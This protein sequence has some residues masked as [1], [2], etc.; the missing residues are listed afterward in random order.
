MLVPEFL[1]I[2]ILGN[3]LLR[4]IAAVVVLLLV[5]FTLIFVRSL[6]VRYLRAIAITTETDLDDL[7][8]E[9]ISR[10]WKMN[11]LAIAIFA[12]SLS[13][14]VSQKVEFLMASLASVAL[15]LQLG[16]WGNGIVA[17]LVTR[18]RKK[19]DKEEKISLAAYS[20]ISW[21]SR[22]VLWS[23]VALLALNNL[24]IEVTALVA[25]L[26]ISGI[27][28]ALAVQNILGDLFASLSIVLD[29]PFEVGD[30][31]IVEDLMGVVQH[32]GIK[33]TRVMS[34]S[35]EQIVFS[36]TDLLSSRIRNYRRMKERRVL[37]GFGVTY[38]TTSEQ[39][40]AIPGII[41]EIV[42][43]LEM[44]RFDR[45]HFKSFG[46]SSLDFEVVYFVQDREYALFMDIQQE[47]NLEIMKRFEKAGIEFAYPTQTLFIE[48]E[49]V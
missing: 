34:I 17:Y 20:A 23:F 39:V 4:W 47:I 45:A 30:F 42:Q 21:I 40:E 22:A 27:A 18:K 28:I 38:Q 14:S 48:K 46:D 2:V 49:S 5:Y 10:T 1:K 44:A 19:E 31:I 13:L 3:E 7:A 25:G 35:G 36:N 26:G 32:V 41:R 43:N 16:L 6:L 11:M 37:F 9:I 29:R 8:V 12:G 33:T 15:F 24:G